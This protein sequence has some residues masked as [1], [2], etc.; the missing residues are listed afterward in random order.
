MVWPVLFE[1]KFDNGNKQFLF[2]NANLCFPV[3]LFDQF[4]CEKVVNETNYVATLINCKS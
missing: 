4:N 3:Q 2:S 1:C